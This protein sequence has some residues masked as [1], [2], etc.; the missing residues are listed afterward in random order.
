MGFGLSYLCDHRFKHLLD[1]INPLCYCDSVI[2]MTYNLFHYCS[3][4]STGKKTSPLGKIS[5]INSDI[6]T[7]NYF[8]TVE[9]LLFDDALFNRFGK[10]AT[11]KAKI[12]SIVSSKIFDDTLFSVLTKVRENA[13]VGWKNIHLLKC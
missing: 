6:L 7:C 10:N 3:N 11:F 8:K 4:F 2:Q 9:T 13:S 12:R 5:E 1:T